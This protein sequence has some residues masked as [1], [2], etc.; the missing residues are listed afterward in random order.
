MS[1]SWW[2]SARV[3]ITT[4]RNSPLRSLLSAFGVMVG[5]G[6]LV[7]ILALGSGLELVMAEEEA[8]TQDP[9]VVLVSPERIAFVNGLIVPPEP[10]MHPTAAHLDSLADVVRGKASV[11]LRVASTERVKVEGIGARVATQV[12]RVSSTYYD[13]DPVALVAGHLDP[14]RAVVN[15]SFV[16]TLGWVP[17]SA[18]GRVVSAGEVRYVISGVIAPDRPGAPPRILLPLEDSVGAAGDSVP[19]VIVLRVTDSTDRTAVIQTARTWVERSF[20]PGAATVSGPGQSY[21]RTIGQIRMVKAVVGAI[22]GIAIVAGAIGVMNIMLAS[23]LERTREIGIRMA[24][25]AR[26]MD[27]R[28]QFLLESIAV[29]L[30]GAVVGIVAGFGLAM[31]VAAV[32]SRISDGAAPIRAALPPWA[33]IGVLAITVGAGAVAGWYPAGRAAR[34]APAEAIRVE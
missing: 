14:A 8:R 10:M 25:G 5:I 23:V 27:I 20:W 19:A 29:S 7:A 1:T 28:R 12:S 22:A 9:N 16:S 3:A 2:V 21:G 32:L 17:S 31:V 30:A 18:L 6:A 4:L 26:R 11:A 33:L 15:E 24:C 13:V 34:L